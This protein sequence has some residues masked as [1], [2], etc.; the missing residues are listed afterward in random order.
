MRRR[1]TGWLVVAVVVLA[2]CQAGTG[3]RSEDAGHLPAKLR[4]GVIPNISPERQRAQYEP[5]RAY[6]PRT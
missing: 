5:F 6:L 3:E 2:G 1:L 4:V